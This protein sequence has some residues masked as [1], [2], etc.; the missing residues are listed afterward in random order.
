MMNSLRLPIIALVAVV[1]TSLLFLMSCGRSESSR[2]LEEIRLYMDSHADSR[3]DDLLAID[4]ATLD[5][6]SDRMLYEVLLT[7]ALD[8]AHESLASRDSVMQV[9]ADWFSARSDTRKAFLATYF[10]GRVKYEKE[11]YPQALAAMFKAHDL[12]KEL[13]DKFWIGMSARGISDIYLDTY[14]AAGA[15]EY[16]KIEL[17]NIRLSGRQPYIDY[18]LLDLGDALCANTQSEE[19]KEILNE[20]T[21]SA[22]LH[23]NPYLLFE[24]K[25]LMARTLLK[26][27]EYERGLEILEEIKLHPNFSLEDTTFLALCYTELGMIDKA[28]SVM[29]SL[30]KDTTDNAHWVKYLVNK[31]TGNYAEALKHKEVESNVQAK[32]ILARFNFDLASLAINYYNVKLQN[33]K[34]E[35]I[36]AKR[37]LWLI[38]I[39]VVLILGITIYSCY[40][41]Y[42]S[43]QEQ[44]E[45]NFILAQNL[46]DIVSQKEFENSEKNFLLRD[47]LKS[48]FSIIDKLCHKLYECDDISIAGKRISKMVIEVIDELSNNKKKIM[49]IEKSVDAICDNIISDFKSD[50]PNLKDI[51]YRVFLYS[52]LGFSPSSIMVFLGEKNI[53]SVYERKRRLKDKI[54]K[55]DN[56]NRERYLECL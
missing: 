39:I 43:S 20:L 28:N 55:L 11:E 4:P 14:N 24:A 26:Q 1:F 35:L 51:D 33:K 45:R 44:I 8:K 19:A 50:F 15:I 49:D 21:D 36:S 34:I 13:D 23:D 52:I 9:A 46:R 18:A 37:T 40:K 38:I 32:R 2:E 56:I 5:G 7:Q 25:E 17:E 30:E 29:E 16:A 3:I 6:E 10:L 31:A 42:S 27:N 53:T 22:I 12:A 54:K 41:Y 48:E 47:K